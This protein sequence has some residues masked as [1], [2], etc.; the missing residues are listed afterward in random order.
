MPDLWPEVSRHLTESQNTDVRDRAIT[1]SVIFGDLA[2]FESLRQRM[3][4]QSETL[5]ARRKALGVLVQ[6]NDASTLPLLARLLEESAMR[7]EAIRALAAYN[8]AST[9]ALILKHYPQWNDAER[10]D[11]VN[12]LASRPAYTRALL[13]VVE[14]GH[15][16][17]REVSAFTA[18]QLAQLDDKALV[19]KL[20]KVWGRVRPESH[21]KA[22]LIQRY[23]AMLT[24]T[25]LKGADLSHGR[26]VY[27]RTCSS[28]HRLFDAGRQVGPELTGSQRGNLD[29]LLTN[30]LDPNATIG[31]DYQVTVVVTTAGRILNGIVTEENK[32]T[33]TIETANDTVVIP[34]GEIE[35]RKR[36]DVSMMPEGMLENL[37]ADELRNLVAYLG[38][39]N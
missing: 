8:D 36:S 38:S 9:P 14:Q 3:L 21:D 35:Q 27:A 5:D 28:C 33:V 39:S 4:D 2:A 13:D 1:L 31:R 18:R 26:L 32:R 11:A 10:Q 22:K 17:S 30:L 12:T 15:I 23:K 37:T 29:Y 25:I 19:A 34:K 7:G 6:A 16:P 24:P 20:Q